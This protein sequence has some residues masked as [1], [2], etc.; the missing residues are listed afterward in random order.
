MLDNYEMKSS[1]HP[2]AQYR[3]NIIP[4]TT[5]AVDEPIVIKTIEPPLIITNVESP[6]VVPQ[7]EADTIVV[8]QPHTV[9]QVIGKEV[10]T[11][12]ENNVNIVHNEPTE[13]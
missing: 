10:D 3:N 12:P 1:Y 2:N 9:N 8:E 7:V 4:I 13:S 6:L 5:T 11:K